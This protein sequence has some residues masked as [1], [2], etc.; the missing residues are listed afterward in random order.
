LEQK[1]VYSI[2]TGEDERLENPVEDAIAMEK[3]ADRAAINDWVTH[4]HT[5]RLTILLGMEP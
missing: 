4:H 1:Q 3:L 2:V 5:V